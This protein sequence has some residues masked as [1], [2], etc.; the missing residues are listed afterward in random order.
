M[1]NLQ[2]AITF[3]AFIAAFVSMGALASALNMFN[4]AIRRLGE[5]RYK[6]ELSRRLKV[7]SECA[8]IGAMTFFFSL[9]VPFTHEWI[10]EQTQFVSAALILFSCVVLGASA[11]LS[12][13]FPQPSV[14]S[15]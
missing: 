2:V 12:E 7:L 3:G 13:Y 10:V 1:N 8:A 6:T 14:T 4:Q 9:M 15:D 11:V 5:P